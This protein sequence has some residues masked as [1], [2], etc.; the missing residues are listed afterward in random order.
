MKGRYA[1]CHMTT[2]GYVLP[3]AGLVARSALRAGNLTKRAKQRLKILDWY[4]SHGKNQSLA[5]RHFGTNRET[6]RTWIR[7]VKQ[8]GPA[9]L[10][11]KSHRPHKPRSII[12]PWEV[13]AEIV[14]VRKAN[15]AWSKYKIA[16][17]M[18]SKI[19]PSTI[20]RILKRKGLI[21][22]KVSRKKR[23]AALHP[24]KRYPRDLVISKPGDL[25]QMDT[26]HLTGTGN[27][28]MYQYTAIDV[29]SKNRI[30]WVATKLSSV[31]GE[32]FLQHCLEAFAFKVQAVQTDNGAEF[33]KHFDRTCQKLKLPHYWTEPRSPKQNSY[34]ERS[35]LTDE[36][37]FYQQGNMRSSVARLLPLLKAWER[38]YNTERPHQSLNYLTPMQYLKKYQK[39]KIPTRDYVALQT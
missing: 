4:Q 18:K 13:Q 24:K 15:P 2:Y 12:T 38:K 25:I 5:S 33:S 34:V 17:V 22:P 37:E 11:D 23:T 28:K 7:T 29:L 8:S 1:G 3:K 31:Q 9:G 39:T 32:K 30:L 36:L 21:N 27:T 16:V 19:S 35:H 26:K 6:L 20:G 14:K 10:N